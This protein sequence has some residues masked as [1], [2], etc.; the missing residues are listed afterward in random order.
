MCAGVCFCVYVHMYAVFSLQSLLSIART[1]G[2]ARKALDRVSLSATR[3]RFQRAA[4]ERQRLWPGVMG[5]CR[6]SRRGRPEVARGHA[7]S[8]G[9]PPHD[10]ARPRATCGSPCRSAATVIGLKRPF[11]VE[12]DVLGFRQLT[13]VE[14]CRA[15][16]SL[17]VPL[18]GGVSVSRF[19]QGG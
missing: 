15:W 2:C 4:M 9:R 17:S 8:C 13:R 10:L 19:S 5:C 14:L 7:R 3:S 16:V 6:R 18:C 11:L 12:V 1:C